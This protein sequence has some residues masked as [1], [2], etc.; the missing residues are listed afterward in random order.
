MGPNALAN[1]GLHLLASTDISPFVCGGKTPVNDTLGELQRMLEDRRRHQCLDHGQDAP[2]DVFPDEDVAESMTSQHDVILSA[3]HQEP[4]MD[5]PQVVPTD[6]SNVAPEIDEGLVDNSLEADI[7]TDEGP[8]ESMSWRTPRGAQ[9][10][11]EDDEVIWRT[12]RWNHAGHAGTL[13]ATIFSACDLR[14]GDVSGLADPYCYVSAAAQRV[15]T[16]TIFANLNPEWNCTLCLAVADEHL[17][18]SVELHV[19]DDDKFGWAGGCAAEDRHGFDD[20][21]GRLCVPMSRVLQDGPVEISDEP[22]LGVKQG[23]LSLRLEFL[24]VDRNPKR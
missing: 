19:W 1:T 12:P 3:R 24:P 6:E 13:K 8:W 10:E 14:K 15:R 21:L 9:L 20:F 11:L 2:S 7:Q 23:T 22:L 4:E 17:S 5:D 18:G 16:P